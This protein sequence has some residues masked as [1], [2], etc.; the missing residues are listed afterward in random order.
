[1]QNPWLSC[2]TVIARVS[3][4]MCVMILLRRS[5]LPNTA[6]HT[7]VCAEAP[8]DWEDMDVCEGWSGRVEVSRML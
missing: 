4:V 1:M 2:S 8:W 7:L 5:G 3:K 6:A